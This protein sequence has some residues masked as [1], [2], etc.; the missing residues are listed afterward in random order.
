MGSVSITPQALGRAVIRET[1]GRRVRR[2]AALADR[3]ED[4]AALANLRAERRDWLQPEDFIAFGRKVDIHPAIIHALT[5]AETEPGQK[6]FDDN[7]RLIILDEPH[8]F[9]ALSRHA[10]DVSH[11]HLSYPKWIRYRR[12][13]PPPAGFDAHPY[14]FD[15]DRR[16]Q[17][18]IEQAQLDFD[19]AC[20]SLSAGRFQ[21][22][23]GSRRPS[24][25]H[26]ALGFPTAWSLLQVLARSEF[27]QLGVLH[28]FLKVNGLLPAFRRMDWRTIARAYNGGGQVA[29]YAGRMAAAYASRRKLY[30]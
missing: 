1:L 15:Q 7:G 2:A 10:F 9:S 19:A 28:L 14:T 11:P 23:T 3:W 25:G 5:D 24:E 16:W 26:V 6:G 22:L 20:G 18:L 17:L 12:G 13:A 27:E 30:A 8:V 21:Q 4:I 29:L